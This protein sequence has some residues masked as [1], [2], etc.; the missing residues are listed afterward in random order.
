MN[1]GCYRTR[2]Q[3]QGLFKSLG[4][5]YLPRTR[6]DFEPL[7]SVR[8]DRTPYYRTNLDEFE[9]LVR[10]YGADIRNAV[11]AP[12][13]I[14]RIDDTIGLGVFAAAPIQQDAFVGEYT[15]VVQV[16]GKDEPCFA[17]KTGHESDYS[18]YYLDKPRGVPDLEINARSEGNEMR[19]VNHGDPPNLKVEHTLIDGHWAL[20]YIAGRDI[21]KD[22]ELFA[23]YGNQYWEDGFRCLASNGG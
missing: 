15:G 22:E 20:F 14:R 12:L 6:V 5:T 21:K 19:F 18:W 16:A 10:T 23:S 11:K 17:A 2:K 3:I 4:V 8:L 7:L 1:N 9:R 13:Y